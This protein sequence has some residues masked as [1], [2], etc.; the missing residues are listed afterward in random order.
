MGFGSIPALAADPRVDAVSRS[1]SASTTALTASTRSAFFIKLFVFVFTLASSAFFI[2]PLVAAFAA[3]AIT[4]VPRRVASAFAATTTARSRA[5]SSAA[6]PRAHGLVS[7]P[8]AP[9]ARPRAAARATAPPPTPRDNIVVALSAHRAVR[10]APS[11][12]RV[13]RRRARVTRPPRARARGRRRTVRDA[14]TRA[15]VPNGASLRVASSWLSRP[16]AR[17]RRSRQ[18][19]AHDVAARRQRLPEFRVRRPERAH[20]LDQTFAPRRI[21]R[22]ERDARARA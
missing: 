9:F 15:R 10:A 1:T 8:R 5:R 16:R 7:R 20:G 2:F 14:R 21:A 11:A 17:A 4:F 6:N 19:F 12:P 13:D 22:D 3:R 18:V